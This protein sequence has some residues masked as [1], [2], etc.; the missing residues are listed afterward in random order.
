MMRL[1]RRHKAHASY[2]SEISLAR[3]LI[4]FR[5]KALKKSHEFLIIVNLFHKNIIFRKAKLPRFASPMTT[6]IAN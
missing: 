3:Q 6:K 2:T 5:G 1:N 4:K